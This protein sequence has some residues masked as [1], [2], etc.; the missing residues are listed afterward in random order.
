MQ[1]DADTLHTIASRG[2]INCFDSLSGET[3][4][5]YTL[6]VNQRHKPLTYRAAHSFSNEDER[7][8][9]DHSLVD[10]KSYKIATSAFCIVYQ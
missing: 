4:S 3:Q 2:L 10:G 6:T 7:P 1:S 8:N 9:Q 5:E